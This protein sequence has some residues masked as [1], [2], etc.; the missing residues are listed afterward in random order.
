MEVI[1]MVQQVR[2]WSFIENWRIRNCVNKPNVGGGEEEVFVFSCK[3]G[4]D[5]TP[6]SLLTTILL[7]LLR[8]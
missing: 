1:L 2:I 4:L 5:P 8:N 7:P 6:F 3:Y